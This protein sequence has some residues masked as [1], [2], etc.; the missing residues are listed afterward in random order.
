MPAY[1]MFFGETSLPLTHHW[2]GLAFRVLS[3]L[4][5][6]LILLV[7]EIFLLHVA[8]RPLILGNLLKVI[9]AIAP[10]ISSKLFKM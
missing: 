9:L 8:K 2:K 7:V 5:K 6:P 1:N 3:S 4:L 10:A